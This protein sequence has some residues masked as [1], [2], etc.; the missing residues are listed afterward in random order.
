MDKKTSEQ[1]LAEINE[2][3]NHREIKRLQDRRENEG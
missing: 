1:I 2:S 3:K